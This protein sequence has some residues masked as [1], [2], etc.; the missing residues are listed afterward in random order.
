M[1]RRAVLA[2]GSALAL[3]SLAGC[4]ALDGLVAR[5]S[6]EAVGTTEASPAAFYAGSS[7]SLTSRDAGE[8]IN[9]Y[10]SDP[11][12]VRYVP[13]TIRAASRDIEIDGWSTST[14]TKA[15]DYNSSRSNKPSSIWVPDPHDEDSDDDGIGTLVTVLDIERALLVYADAALEA[16]DSR[17][18]DDAKVSLDAFINATTKVRSELEG[19]PSE[20]CTTVYENADGRKG[21]AQDAIDAVDAGEWDSA[22]KS[23]QQARRI[24]QGDIDRIFD[25]LDSD[26]D[27]LV[28][29][30]EPLYEY[31]AGEPTIGERFVV[32]LPDARV[33]GDG[34]AL[35]DKLTPQRVL[36]YVTGERDAEGCADSDGTVAVHR[37]L[38]CRDLL[39]AT[40]R[41]QSADGRGIDKKDIR[42]GVVAF[43]TSGGVVVTGA[44]PDADGAE[45][46]LFVSENGSATAP[47]RLDSWG[48][49]RSTGEATISSTLVC[50]VAAQPPECPSPMPA[51][52]YVRRILHDDQL[53]YAGGWLIDDGALYEDTA[54]LL[55]GDG[56]NVVSRVTRSDVEEGG[57]DLKSRVTG[58]RKPGRTTYGTMTLRTPYDANADYLPPGAHPVCRD[59]GD[60][61]CWGVQSR[62]ALATHT[63]DCDDDDR[64]ESP[65]C[66]VTALDAPVLHLAGA[67]DASNDVKFKAGAELSKSVN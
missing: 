23:I 58:R 16:V 14:P 11:D 19:C 24:V 12:D 3:G 29:G 45:P 52:L 21:L 43:E 5:A 28:D 6:D 56:P 62:E 13:P 4:T 40:L 65:S 32:S 60:I 15:Q 26:D 30:T 66:V 41:A 35:A 48:D 59:D 18:N 22:R 10:R 2:G 1:T 7:S 8:M 64:T 20:T 53:L 38:S 36:E 63:G 51:L 50:P 49:E 39:S 31:L 55:V 37:D 44:S 33:R 47:E 17:S 57:V 54:T 34:P 42:R 27:G 61:Y 9:L 46:S 67:A 25:D